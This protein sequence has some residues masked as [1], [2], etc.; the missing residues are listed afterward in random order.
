MEFELRI[1][2]RD[3]FYPTYAK[4]L[5]QHSFPIISKVW[6]P[7]KAF[8]SYKDNI[9][10]HVC[11]FFETDSCLCL[12]GFPASD[13]EL[14]SEFKKGGLE[15]VFSEMIEYAKANHYVSIST[16]S[17]PLRQTIVDAL[18]ENEFFIADENVINLIK[19]LQ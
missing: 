15:F 1:Q 3:E 17:H 19:I 5:E 7:E 8:V 6:M 16:Y 18:I 10:T 13:K 11:W 14:D 9:P 2:S 4:W 12:I